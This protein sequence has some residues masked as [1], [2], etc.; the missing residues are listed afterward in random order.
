[1]SDKPRRTAHM[2]TYA[3]QPVFTAA[4]LS[5]TARSQVVITDSSANT[6][7]ITLPALAES[8]MCIIAVEAEHGN[9]NDVSVLEKEGGTEVTG[10]DLDAA[11]DTGVYMNIG[12]R[13][14]PLKSND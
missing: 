3:D 14:V 10:G 1:M 2:E 12:R 9:D 7:D 8:F 6:V 13:W 11:N 4:D 5:L